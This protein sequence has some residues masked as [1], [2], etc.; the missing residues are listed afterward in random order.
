V[1]CATAFILCFSSIDYLQK[2]AIRP[3]N[4]QCSSSDSFAYKIVLNQQFQVAY[5]I[6]I[7][8][9]CGVRPLVYLIGGTLLAMVSED[10]S[11]TKLV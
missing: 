11:P 9:F 5:D 6:A 10:F 7:L 8:Y 3:G 4:Y 1:D 2:T